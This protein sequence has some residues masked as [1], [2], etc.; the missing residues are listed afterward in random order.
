MTVRV[1]QPAPG[2][3]LPDLNGLNAEG[4]HQ[5]LW[6]LVRPERYLLAWWHPQV[7]TPAA[8]KTCGGGA[9][10]PLELIQS[11]YAAGCDLVGLSY[12]PPERTQRYL[13]SIGLIYPIL[14][15]E[16]ADSREHG[17][18]KGEDEPWHTVP[19]QVAFLIN[20]QHEVIN[21]YE[22]HDPAVFLRVVHADV[23]SGP[24]PSMWTPVQKKSFWRKLLG[25]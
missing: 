10:E 12:D 21:R 16:R 24:P 3:V 4:G 25:R 5:S 1:A 2:E 18:L 7:L 20:D 14:S 17:V 6:G 19:R 15:V 11:I 9:L 8:C 22:V 23:T 13:D